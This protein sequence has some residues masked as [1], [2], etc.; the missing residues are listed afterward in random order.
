MRTSIEKDARLEICDFEDPGFLISVA[1]NLPDSRLAKRLVRGELPGQFGKTRL[2]PESVAQRK[3]IPL[4]LPCFNQLDAAVGVP[5][6]VEHAQCVWPIEFVNGVASPIPDRQVQSAIA[7]EISRGD[8]G[9]PPGS[10]GKAPL[11][12]HLLKVSIVI[13][14]HAH[15]TPFDRQRQVRTTISV[16]VRQ[17]GAAHQAERF[18]WFAE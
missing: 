7:V 4:V 17:R 16:Q 13:S 12:S 2:K 8:A 11:R 10:A 18:K 15:R 9:P 14:K 1:E 6:A 5:I 3:P